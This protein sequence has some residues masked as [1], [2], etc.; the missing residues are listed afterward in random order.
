MD[1]TSILLM[2]VYGY[3]MYQLG[4]YTTQLNVSKKVIEAIVAKVSIPVGVIEQ[5]D[6]QYYVYDKDT[7]NFLGQADS[8]EDLPKKLIAN[9]IN[10]ALLM[11]PE[12][13][14]DI[15]WCINGKLKLA[16]EG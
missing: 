13:S 3:G 1:F 16:N 2:I 6:N 12:K 8:L 7:N 14:S 4:R 15:Y 10:L 11:Y 9:K 5:I